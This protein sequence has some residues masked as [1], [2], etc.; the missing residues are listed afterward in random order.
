MNENIKYE[1]AIAINEVN[2]KRQVG[3]CSDGDELNIA[4]R[5]NEN[6]FEKNKTEV[7]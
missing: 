7:G 6:D 3:D 2:L 4:K 5:A 1:F